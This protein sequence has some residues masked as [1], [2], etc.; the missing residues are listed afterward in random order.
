[1]KF[2]TV[3]GVDL[4]HIDLLKTVAPN[5]LRYR[6]EIAANPM[7]VVVDRSEGTA[8][9]WSER[10]DKAL[11]P[12][13]PDTKVVPYDLEGCTNQRDKMLNGLFAAPTWC[14][15]TDYFLKL[16][17]DA[18]ASRRDA[19]IQEEWFEECPAFVASPWGYTKPGSHLADCEEWSKK[20]PTLKNLP[21]T[22]TGDPRKK[23]RFRNKRVISYVYFGNTLWHRWAWGLVNMSGMDR[24]PCPS[25]DSFASWLAQ[26]TGSRF[27]RVQMKSYG[28]HHSK[29]KAKR[30]R[31]D[32]GIPDEG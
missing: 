11:G 21:C 32:G 10:I 3:I 17:L 27:K 14:V 25:Q 19:W 18:V 13:Y 6:P 12:E 5:W 22:Y 4:G 15:D 23:L 16:D 26:K 28:W 20:V 2:T 7:R 1:M 24:L 30:V 8:E 9:Q 31:K 29:G